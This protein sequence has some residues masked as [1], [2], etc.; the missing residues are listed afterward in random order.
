MPIFQYKARDDQGR[1]MTGAVE[2]TDLQSAAELL[3]EKRL[4]I[5][6]IEEQRKKIV[7][8]TSINLFNTVKIR[9]VVV[10]SRQLA[11][12]VSANVPLV[13][14]LRL[15]GKQT[16][17][18]AL[19]LVVS[20]VA[21]DVE[22]GARLSRAL[23]R[24]P[25][26]F[27]PFFVH[28]VTSGETTGKIDEVLNSLAD[29]LEKDYDLRSRLKGSMIYPGFI[30]GALIVIGSLMMIFV[31]PKFVEVLIQSGQALPLPTRILIGGSHIM[32]GWWWAILIVL[33][34]GT[35]GAVGW[36]RTAAGERS[37]DEWKLRLPIFGSIY[38]KIYLT[39]LTESLSSLIHSGVPLTQALKIA[40][41]IVGNAV[42]RDLTLE[43]VK[44]V[45]VG[46]SIANVY[47]RSPH[48]PPMVSHMMRIGEET[49]RLD[50]V[51]AK[52]GEFYNRE[53]ENSV[54]NL[55]TLM[56]PLIFVILGIGALILV[57]GILLPVYQLS[58]GGI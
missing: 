7:F 56:E 22:G 48:V 5:V 39:R 44:E 26:V 10:F 16:D 24:H 55:M 49:G 57:L 31:I 35:V 54:K 32:R 51:L 50:F 13:R 1:P 41:N 42:Y 11:V 20:Q 47:S 6:D 34:G 14:A 52:L 33:V 38:Q 40:S 3:R 43:T 19:K 17:S 23:S 29:R 30:M 12:M 45:E 36:R 27:T 37:M 46:Q 28:M 2:A 18:I 53:V 8:K 9:E 25:K 4:L 21:D 15:I 58:S